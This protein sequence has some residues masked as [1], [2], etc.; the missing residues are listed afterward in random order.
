VPEP[1]TITN[2]RIAILG[3]TG[4][5]GREALSILESLDVPGANL[6]LFASSRSAGKRLPYRDTEIEIQEPTIERLAPCDFAILCADA[7]TARAWA[8]RL[9]QHRV[10][11]IDNSAAFR[12]DQ[13]VPLIIPE[14]NGH[15]LKTGDH[16]LIANPNCSTIM[17]LAALEPIRRAFGIS[18]ITVSTYQAVSGAGAAGIDELRTQT[19]AALRNTP[20]QPTVF[21]HTCAFNVFEHESPIDPITGF[22]GEESKMIAETHKIF[23]DDSIRVFPTCIRVPVERAHAQ[24]IVIDL[25]KPATSQTLTDTLASSGPA[26]RIEQSVTP[27]NAAN[28]DEVFVGRIRIEI[29]RASCRERV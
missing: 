20:Q 8:P 19:E 15:L 18:S 2:T 12:M 11:A 22:N 10:T 17:L 5:V 23:A 3:A 16:P 24:S 27:Q 6:E 9:A 21:P 26:L 1:T 7:D 4:A 29:G 13:N 25:E 28:H 14:V